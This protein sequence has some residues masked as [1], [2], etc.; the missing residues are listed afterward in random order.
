MLRIIHKLQN[1]LVSLLLRVVAVQ[2]GQAEISPAYRAG[3]GVSDAGFRFGYNALLLER[4]ASWD[5]DC[6]QLMISKL[7]WH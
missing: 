3:G 4:D 6:N 2:G 1:G 7:A 5:G